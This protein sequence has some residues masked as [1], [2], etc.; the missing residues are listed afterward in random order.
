MYIE[1][2]EVPCIKGQ[3]NYARA[4]RFGQYYRA[5]YNIGAVKQ[6]DIIMPYKVVDEGK[7]MSGQP[8]VKVFYMTPEENCYFL[9]AKN[10]EPWS[11][12]FTR[13]EDE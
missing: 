7:W 3:P 6:G 9:F 13:L 5:C 4:I 12:R 2:K 11:N 8:Q 10:F 1:A